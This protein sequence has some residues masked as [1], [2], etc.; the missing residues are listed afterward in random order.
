MKIYVYNEIIAYWQND[1]LDFDKKILL[2]SLNKL[3][4]GL[5]F[6]CN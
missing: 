3:Y 6:I 4:L 5:K 1:K 2:H